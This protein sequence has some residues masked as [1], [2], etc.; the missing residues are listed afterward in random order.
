MLGDVGG[1][2]GG[3]GGHH[4]VA[5]PIGHHFGCHPGINIVHYGV[6]EVGGLL[7]G[8]IRGLASRDDPQ[9]MVCGAQAS[10]VVGI[11]QGVRVGL[12]AILARAWVGKLVNCIW[13]ILLHVAQMCQEVAANIR[14]IFDKN[15]ILELGVGV[16]SEDGL[17][18]ISTGV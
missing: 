8:L 11:G 16:L 3:V 4:C 15:G 1:E 7:Q 18:A 14:N 5:E 2:F 10:V 13:M 12:D 6:D 9:T 17:D